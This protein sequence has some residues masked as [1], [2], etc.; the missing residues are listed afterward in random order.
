M[1]GTVFVDVDA[2]AAD[3]PAS[4][5]AV[6]GVAEAVAGVALMLSAGVAAVAALAPVVVLDVP[7][8]AGA[9]VPVEVPEG[10]QAAAATKARTGRPSER[11]VV[12]TRAWDDTTEGR[13]KEEP[14]TRSTAREAWLRCAA[15]RLRHSHQ[16][17]SP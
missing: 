6:V 13:V 9:P 2:A 17:C 12:M 7:E 5:G 1:S 10:V 15:I 3:A 4:S 16:R 11:K 14:R 8:L